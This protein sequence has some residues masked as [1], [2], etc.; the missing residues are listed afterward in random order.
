MLDMFALIAVRRGDDAALE[1]LISKYT[2][3]VT[4]VIRGVGD[5]SITVEDVEEIASDVFFALWQNVGKPNPLKLK[6]YLGQIARNKA[7]N[8]LRSRKEELPFE[9]DWIADE[10]ETLVDGLTRESE[11]NAVKSAVLSLSEP[12]REI[13][14]RH[15]YQLQT[16]TMI[17]DE[18]KMGESAI[19]HRLD[20]GRLK[21]KAILIKG[22]NSNE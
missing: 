13:F 6:A 16:V 2:P 20:R 12:D 7:K 22:G 15:Y 14:L 8:R 10:G 4:T 1:Q 21:L 18:M 19:K 3:Y 9:D 11:Q 17:A 5:G